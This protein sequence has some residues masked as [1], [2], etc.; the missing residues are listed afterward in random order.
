MQNNVSN[1]TGLRRNSVSFAGM[2][3]LTLAGV[4]AIIGPIE[5]ASFIGDAGPAAMWPVILGYL[6]F[7]LVSL[8][9]LEYT[10]IAPFAGGYYGLAELGFGRKAGKFT[11]LSNYFFYN[12]WQMANAFFIGWLAIDTVYIIYGIMLPIWF[13]LLICVLTLVITLVMTIQPARLLSRILVIVMVATTVLVTAFTIYVIARSPY[14]SAYYI[15]PANSPSGFTGI[16]LATAVLG[17]YLFAG[18][19]A[20]LFYGEE[21]VQARRTLWKAVYV[22]LTIS[23]VVIALSA[24]SEVVSVPKSD[25]ANVGQASI[26]Q[27]VTWI[28][29][30]PAG[31]LVGLNMF[32]LVVSMIAYGAGGGSQARLLW[33]MS[34]DNFIKSQWLRKLDEKTQVPRRAAMVNF[35]FAL[36]TVLVVAAVLVKVYGYNADTVSLGFFV[37]GTTSTILWYFHH[38]VPEF[39]LYAF[40]SRHRE[41]KFSTARKVLSGLVVP[42]GGTALFVYTFYEGIIG[43]LVEPYF[44]FVVMALLIVVGV[45]AYTL[46]KARKGELGE[47]VVSYMV[48]E[49]GREG[50][51]R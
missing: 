18:Y 17:F 51:E 30:I 49:A 14:N 46:Y 31:V 47:S 34:R 5:I 27:L 45:I 36:F 37:A 50:G 8:P 3:M 25:L 35:A 16:A 10:R 40:L 4:L 44:G 9:I 32:I 24:Y 38:F 28:H 1:T 42:I 12:F 26:P 13:W 48:A 7:V 11:S 23:A 41:I 19:G 33:A 43:N 22:G 20:A 21:G 39:G 29:Y 15:N 2:V 6:L